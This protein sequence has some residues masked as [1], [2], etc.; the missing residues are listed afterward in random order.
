M[1]L[2][3]S[4]PAAFLL[5]SLAL[6]PF[7]MADEAKDA[8]IAELEREVRMLQARI[9]MPEAELAEQRSKAEPP[10]SSQ[11]VE[12]K[13]ETGEA[14]T[15]AED[16]EAKTYR[17][18]EDILR[19]VPEPWQP[20]LVKGWDADQMQ[21]ARLWIEENVVGQTF[22]SRQT[23]SR[24]SATVSH[25]G[26]EAR[27]STTEYRITTSLPT[28]QLTY[29]N[30]PIQVIFRLPLQVGDKSR[31]EQLQRLEQRPAV[32]VAGPITGF[33]LGQFNNR[34]TIYLNLGEPT[35]LR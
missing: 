3:N 18:I 10:E 4:I 8:R 7:G 19:A 30:R 29:R 26:S 9:A 24:V 17:S 20:N 34:V 23:V 2:V 33:R 21:A 22:R 25:S 5:F 13:E 14:V 32:Q 6:A 35:T 1:K 11:Q 27:E 31:F 28:R 12:V 16:R 15:A